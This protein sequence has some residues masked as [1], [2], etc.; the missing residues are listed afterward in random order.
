GVSLRNATTGAEAEAVRTFPDGSFDGYLRLVPGENRIEVVARME[1]GRE[2][3]AARSVVFVRPEE[4]SAE[5]R[6][7]AGLLLDALRVRTIET[8]LGVRA[9]QR[10]PQERELD[11]SIE[12]AE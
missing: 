4:P 5:E 1:D 12:E 7:A 8:E 11:V 3:R 6:A 10:V 2:A 9:R